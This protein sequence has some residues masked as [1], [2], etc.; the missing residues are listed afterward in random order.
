MV[1]F[2]GK[3]TGN[4]KIEESASFA[5][6]KSYGAAGASDQG[7]KEIG[8]SSGDSKLRENLLNGVK[9]FITKKF[10][11]KVSM[12]WATEQDTFLGSLR[13]AGGEIAALYE[14]REY[15]KALR[16]VMD[17]ADAVN[18]YVDA[19]KPWELAKDPANNAKLQEVCSRLLEAFRVLSIYLKPVLP[20]LAT[21]VEALLNIAPLTWDDVTHPLPDQH[22][23]NAYSHLMTRVESKMLDDLF[24][25]PETPAAA[26]AA[27]DIEAIDA[28][29]KI[30]DFAKV[31]L[32][33]AKIVECAHVEDSDKLLRLTL[34]VG[35]GRMR[36][37][38]SGIKSAYQPE[39]LVGK[40]T[41]LVAN[42]AP[43]KMKFGVS[44]GMVLAASAQDEKADPG[45]YILEP[46]PCA[47]PTASK[48][49]AH[50]PKPPPT[51]RRKAGHSKTCCTAPCVG[52]WT[53][54]ERMVCG[55]MR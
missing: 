43:R 49:T 3:I 44:E 21:Q 28:E 14:A 53:A 22:V 39:Q 32:R 11:G 40:L 30:D 7:V 45:I 48:A 10:D 27:T 4:W 2:A 24:D 17:Q 1:P 55:S 18:V 52:K 23:V 8:D 47:K 9:D 35:E 41:V 25:A 37:V 42:L 34:D 20:T 38:F 5:D 16:A 50:P 13:H 54:R 29:I 15:S 31:D 36:N 46:W 26:P 51:L 19:N 12:Q 33:I 6:A